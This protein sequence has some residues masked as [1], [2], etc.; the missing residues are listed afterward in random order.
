M[1]FYRTLMKQSRSPFFTHFLQSLSIVFRISATN[2]SLCKC[3]RLLRSQDYA[4]VCSGGNHLLKL[5]KEF[6]VRY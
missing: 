6:Q 4:Y 1:I 3:T 5:A 2:A